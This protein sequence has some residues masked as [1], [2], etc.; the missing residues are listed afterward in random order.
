MKPGH[1]SPP[2]SM[3][4]VAWIMLVVVQYVGGVVLAQG[5][6]VPQTQVDFFSDL[7]SKVQQAGP[8]AALVCMFFLWRSEK[9]SD[10][11][12]AE[13]DGLLERVITGLNNATASVASQTKTLERAMTLLESATA[14][15][16]RIADREAP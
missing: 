12:L 16:V 3:I 4:A 6:G 14:L 2:T 13:R 1:R 15:L 11:L 8:F 9:R 10:Q 7:W 5:T